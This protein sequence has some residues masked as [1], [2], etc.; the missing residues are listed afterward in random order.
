[1][2][3]EKKLV[4]PRRD[5]ITDLLAESENSSARAPSLYFGGVELE[6]PLTGV[7][8]PAPLL[9]GP[10]LLMGVGAIEYCCDNFAIIGFEVV[11]SSADELSSFAK[12]VGT[13]CKCKGTLIISFISTLAPIY[14]LG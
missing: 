4:S 12:L 10:N 8:K 14:R 1:M 11:E 13:S 7:K 6:G 2:L 5:T 3:R 9:V